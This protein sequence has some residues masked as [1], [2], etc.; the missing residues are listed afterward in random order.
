MKNAKLY[1]GLLLLL[2][3]VSF[4]AYPFIAH[5]LTRPSR[6]ELLHKVDHKKILAAARKMMNTVPETGFGFSSN[7]EN[8]IHD[9]RVPDAIQELN[10]QWISVHDDWIQIEFAGGF[11]HYGLHA[12]RAGVKPLFGGTKIIAGL[13]YYSE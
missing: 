11:D 9:A 5:V 8:P 6:R 2:G 7:P 10:P 13:Y 3:T 1:V 4:T 12:Y